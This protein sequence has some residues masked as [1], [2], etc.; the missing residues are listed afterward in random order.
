MFYGLFLP[1]HNNLS[2]FIQ[3]D[4]EH[5]L[6]SQCDQ[7]IL[8]KKES[9]GVVFSPNYPLPYQVKKHANQINLNSMENADIIPTDT[10]T[11]SRIYLFCYLDK[12]GLS[13]FHLRNEGPSKFG[14]SKVDIR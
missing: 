6:G 13:I 12:R 3:P 8:S 2:D 14:K 10:F 5:I 4:A 11:Y 9:S 7:K 1:R